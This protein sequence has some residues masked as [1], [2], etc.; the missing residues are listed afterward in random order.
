MSIILHGVSWWLVIVLLNCLQFWQETDKAAYL[1]RQYFYSNL[2]DR[3]ST[4]PF[5]SLV[6]KKWLA[7]QVVFLVLQL[8]YLRFKVFWGILFSEFCLFCSCFLLWSSAMRR[9]YVMVSF[10]SLRAYDPHYGALNWCVWICNLLGDIKCE[11]VLLTSWN[12]LYLADFA[13]FKPTYIPYDDPSDFSFF[14]DTRGQRLCYL[15]PEVLLSK[16]FILFDRPR[17]VKLFYCTSAESIIPLFVVHHGWNLFI[18]LL[19][20]AGK[21]PSTENH[22]YVLVMFLFFFCHVY[23]V[24]CLITEILWAWRWDTSSTRCS[25][26]TIHGYIC[27]GVSSYTICFCIT[28]SV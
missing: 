24:C 19:R 18:S 28:L 3:L 10:N 17:S 12:W 6:E 15:A 1:V 23:I 9:I 25:I 7:F 5:L 20:S 22:P 27:R 14:F 11:N 26:K 4:R 13:S 21:E 16:L 8:F 2:H